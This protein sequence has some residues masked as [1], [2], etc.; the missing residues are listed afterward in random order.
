MKEAQ[1]RFLKKEKQ[2]LRDDRYWSKKEKKSKTKHEKFCLKRG[3]PLSKLK[4]NLIDR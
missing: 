2:K 1:K 4:Y 3:R